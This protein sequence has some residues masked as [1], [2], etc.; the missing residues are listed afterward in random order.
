VLLLMASLATVTA[1][2]FGVVSRQGGDGARVDI[3]QLLLAVLVAVAALVAGLMVWRTTAVARRLTRQAHAENAELRRNLATAEAIIKAE[4]QVLVYWEQDHGLK[5]VAH[6]LAGVAGIPKE[7]IELLRFGQWLE[8]RSAEGLRANLDRLFTEG[9]PFSIILKTKSGE[10]LDADGR[11]AGG[12]AVLRLRDVAGYRRDLSRIIDQHQWLARDIRSGRALLNALPMPVWLK[13][14]DGR[15]SWVNK[16]YVAAVEAAGE[17]EVIERQIEL[18]ESRQRQA[19]TRRLAP[20]VPYRDRLAL[21]VGG[22]RKPH[23]VIVLPLEDGTAGAAI[24]VAAIES[25]KGELDR[26]IAAYDRTLDRVATAVAI[27]DREQKLTFFNEAY[28]KLWQLDPEWLAGKPSDGSIL[29]RLRELGRLPE[30]VSYREWKSKILACYRNGA[31]IEDWWHLP[32]G[33]IL[34]VFSEQRPD[35]GV[36]HLYVDESERFA[37]ESN[38][39]ALINVQRETLDSLQEGVVVFGTDGRIKLHNRA[40]AQIWKLQRETLAHTPPHID[41]LIALVR[42]LYDE[43]R[44]WRRLS[45]AVTSFSDERDAVEGQM[46]R[47]DNSVIDFAAT[48]LPDGGT[49]ITFVDVTDSKRY[50]RALL[51]RNEALVAADRLKNQFIGHVSYELRTPLTNIIGFT[52]MLAGGIGGPLNHRQHEYLADIG[53]SSRTLLAI[54]DDILDIAT[55]D[56]G[57]LELKLAP[58][59]VRAV[60]DSAVAGVAARAEQAGITLDLAVADD[61]RSFVADEHRVR[62][63]L[64]NLLANAVGFSRPKGVV[65][66]TCWREAGSIAFEVEDQ[67]VGIPLDQQKRLFQRFETRSQGSN[68]RGAG[69][70]LSIAKS[71]VEAHGGT[72]E[73]SSVPGEGTRALVRFPERGIGAGEL[74]DDTHGRVA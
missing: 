70:G 28:L 49:L 57:A 42:V 30:T 21:V 67:G 53:S 58:V 7:Q 27:F 3:D 25:A 45:R 41:E 31:G 18:L 68:H 35:G 72:L 23:D 26:Q 73:I 55:I 4:P 74:V 61:A 9:R 5:V 66:L 60:I 32:D 29:D 33:R 47:P 19:L 12:R 71:L 69:L 38:Y 15:I 14:A 2:T 43:P 48:P 6:T 10:H 20:G 1:L 51:E 63:V 46:V 16:A 36:T 64:H 24:D 11:A 50:E 52:E 22:E 39:N 54:I 17:D 40:F 59:G 37:L 65:R 13:G 8:Q 34:H 62:Q 56:A 44:T